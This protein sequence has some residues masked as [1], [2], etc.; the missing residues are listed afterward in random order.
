MRIQTFCDSAAY[1]PFPSC[2]K[3]VISFVSDTNSIGREVLLVPSKNEKR[4]YLDFLAGSW[5]CAKG[6]DTSFLLVRFYNGGNCQQ[7]ERIEGFGLHGKRLTVEG[8]DFDA[9]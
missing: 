8:K 9:Q 4:Q 5:A 1:R 7:C 6:R 3:Q 2:T